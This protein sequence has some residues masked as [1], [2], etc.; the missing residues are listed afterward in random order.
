MR[1][2]HDDHP[3]IADDRALDLR[4]SEQVTSYPP[5]PFLERLGVL[6]HGPVL[7]STG[8]EIG[9]GLRCVFAYPEGLLLSIQVKAIGQAASDAHEGDRHGSRGGSRTGSRRQR[10]PDQPL[11]PMNFVRLSVVAPQTESGPEPQTA[12]PQLRHHLQQVAHTTRGASE[13]EPGAPVHVQDIDVWWPA[14]P[15][16]SRLTVQAGWPELGAPLTTRVLELRGLDR[17]EEGAVS[18]R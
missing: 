6:A 7:L 8:P 1:A 2:E 13:D 4:Q 12:P 16:R 14:L 3:H 18:L 17:L 10:R 11:R 9:I 5:L 15:V